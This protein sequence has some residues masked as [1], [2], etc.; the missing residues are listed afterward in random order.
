MSARV[1][2]GSLSGLKVSWKK[3]PGAARYIVLRSDSPYGTYRQIGVAGKPMYLDTGLSP[4]T[5]YYYK[6]Y[7]VSGSCETNTAGPVRQMTKALK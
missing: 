6:V 7:A 4:S 5:N 2:L 3:V 1:V